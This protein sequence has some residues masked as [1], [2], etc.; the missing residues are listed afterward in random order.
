MQAVPASAVLHVLLMDVKSDEYDQILRAATIDARRLA[1]EITGL[2]RIDVFGTDDR[3]QVLIV[4]Q[5]VDD[6]S[7]GKAQ[8]ADDVQKAIVARFSEA[9]RVHSKLYRR[10]V[11]DGEPQAAAP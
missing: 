3:T 5:W 2:L 1:A 7:W 4:S 8:W 11:L 6:V 10:I 9:R